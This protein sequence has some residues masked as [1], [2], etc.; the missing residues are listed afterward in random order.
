MDRQG[1]V[2]QI[3]ACGMDE[4]TLNVWDVDTLDLSRILRIQQHLL[5]RPVGKADMV[6]GT[7]CCEVLPKGVKTTGSLQLL[8]N[9]FGYCVKGR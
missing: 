7:D 4:I 5:I 6:I 1:K 3:N 2:W 9:Q 8:K